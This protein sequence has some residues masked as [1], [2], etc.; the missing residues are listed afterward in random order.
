M[1]QAQQVYSFGGYRWE[2]DPRWRH[3]LILQAQFVATLQFDLAIVIHK[4]A[5]AG[6]NPHPPTVRSTHLKELFGQW[7][8][9]HTLYPTKTDVVILQPKT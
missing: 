8:A 1:K 5:V 6:R 4:N 9:N 3:D 2:S 7:V